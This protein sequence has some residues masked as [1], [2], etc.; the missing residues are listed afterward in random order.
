MNTTQ[1]RRVAHVFDKHGRDKFC[2]SLCGNKYKLGHPGV[3]IYTKE[4]YSYMQVNQ[5]SYLR[6][7]FCETCT[8]LMFCGNVP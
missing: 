5:E 6:M 4:D 7:T 1:P 8:I 2:Y 3:L